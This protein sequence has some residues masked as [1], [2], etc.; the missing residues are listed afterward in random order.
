MTSDL[1]AALPAAVR[2]NVD[3]LVVQGRSVQ[4]VFAIRS[5][6]VAPRPGLRACQELIAERGAALAGRMGPPPL[7]DL[8]TLAAEVVALPRPVVA[9]EADWDG[10]TQGR[11]VRLLA[12]TA[13]PGDQAG[14]ADPHVLAHLRPGDDLRDFDG[15]APPWPEQGEAVAVGRALAERF[16]VPFRFDGSGGPEVPEPPVRPLSPGSPVPPVLPG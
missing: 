13:G 12:V 11:F 5:S 3:E 2:E 8:E 1:W 15:E 7:R 4:A 16:G 9:I 14:P 6:G 10:D